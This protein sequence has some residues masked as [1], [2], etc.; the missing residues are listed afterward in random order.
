MDAAPRSKKSRKSLDEMTPAEYL[1]YLCKPARRRPEPKTLLGY[2]RRDFD[3][4]L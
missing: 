3:G 4:A 1:A 2:L